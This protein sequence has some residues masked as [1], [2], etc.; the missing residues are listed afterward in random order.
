M[1]IMRRRVARRAVHRFSREHIQRTPEA[2]VSA[3]KLAPRNGDLYPGR[4][5]AGRGR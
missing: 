2:S 3:P 5:A 4:E 1:A